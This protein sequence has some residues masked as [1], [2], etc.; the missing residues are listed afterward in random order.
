M[1]YPVTATFYDLIPLLNPEEY[2]HT[3]AA[4]A[5]HYQ[6]KL[7]NLKRADGLLA[8]SQFSGSRLRSIEYPTEQ[9]AVAPQ[10]VVLFQCRHDASRERSE[11]SLAA[12]GLTL[13][14]LYVGGSDAH[15]IYRVLLRLGLLCRQ[16]AG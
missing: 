7:E 5:R 11:S 10:P 16:P 15:K 8:I 2:L 1:D 9:I 12:L 4:F 3:N 6:S 13:V 14:L